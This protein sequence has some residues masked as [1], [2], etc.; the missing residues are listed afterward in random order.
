MLY[1]FSRALACTLVEMLTCDPPH[2]EFWHKHRERAKYLFIQGA[3][4]G[5]KKQLQYIGR[6]LVPKASG[7]V[8]KLL[9]CLFIRNKD[10]RPGSQDILNVFHYDASKHSYT[11]D[12]AKLEE[13]RLRINNEEVY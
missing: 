3:Q 10:H 7:S 4:P 13:L 1:L 9:D 12:P 5:S 8:Q 6:E 2:I 11:I